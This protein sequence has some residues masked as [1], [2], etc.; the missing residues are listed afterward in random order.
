MHSLD[1]SEVHTN[2]KEEASKERKKHNEM[3]EKM[4]HKFCEYFI[5]I[6]C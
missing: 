2:R 5:I 4:W 6:I 3:N 1:S